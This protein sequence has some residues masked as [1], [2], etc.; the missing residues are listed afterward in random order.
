MQSLNNNEEN[1][2]PSKST[3]LYVDDNKELVD[4]ISAYLSEKYNVLVASN[5]KIGIEMAI[6]WYKKFYEGA[7]PKE[8]MVEDLKILSKEQ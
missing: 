1:V 8:L 2:D 7:S 5:G 6:Q 3:I 4:K